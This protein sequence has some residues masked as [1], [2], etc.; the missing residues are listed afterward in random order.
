M[1]VLRSG[2]NT[3]IKRKATTVNKIHPKYKFKECSIKLNRLSQSEIQSHLQPSSLSSS[4]KYN[5]R[6]KK[7][8][9]NAPI[10]C[11]SIQVNV[12]ERQ[13][14]VVPK[15]NV[16]WRDLLKQTYDF[17]PTDIVLA[18]MANFRPWPARINSIYK[19]GN[20]LKCYVLFYGTH[21]I[22]SVLKSQCVKFDACD[23]FLLNTID[24]IKTKYNCNLDYEKLSDTEDM[25]RALAIQKLTQVQ[26]FLLAI[27]DA[28]RLRHIPLNLSMLQSVSI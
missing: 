5:L 15:S 22:G 26:K 9:K 28:E 3:I 16:I 17:R 10:P 14:A 12:N 8:Q 4:S 23:L 20:V 24:E 18:K 7:V 11:T 21:Q 1:A 25:G 19:V 2:K 13:V 6:Q 27:R